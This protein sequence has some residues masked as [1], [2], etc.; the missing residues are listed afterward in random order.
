MLADAD[1]KEIKIKYHFSE[2]DEYITLQLVNNN[3][4]KMTQFS[5]YFWDPDRDMPTQFFNK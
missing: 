1:D 5:D 2:R 4:I 3:R